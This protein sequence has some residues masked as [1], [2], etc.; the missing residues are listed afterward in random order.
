M[1]ASIPP[2]EWTLQAAAHLLNR[3]GFGGTPGEIQ[4]LHALGQSR[5]IDFL[6]GAD[7]ESDLFPAPDLELIA[8]KIRKIRS[9]YLELDKKEE[10]LA[11]ARREER[12]NGL[13]LR[14]WWLRRMR[15]TPNPARE[16]A[17][18]F[19]H[20][21]WA[22]SI[23]KVKNPLFMYRQNETLR[24]YAFGRF[25]PLAKE[26][27]RDPAMIRYLDLDSSSAKKPNENF[28]RE[29][30]E[31]FTLGEGNYSETDISE[32]ARA[33]AGYR[34]NKETGAFRFEPRQADCGTK[35]V[36]GTLGMHNGDE[37]IDIIVAKP[38]CAE[39]LATKIWS[40]YAETTPSKAFQKALGEEYVRTG[41][42]AGKFLRVLFLSREFYAPNVVRHQIKSPVQWL[43]QMCKILEIPLPPDNVT[44]PIMMNLGQNL[45]DP[46]NV[47][48]WNGA[49]A[50]INS[51]TL[52]L[53]YN[54]AGK[55]IRGGGGTLPDIDKIIPS[56]LSPEQSAEALA[57]RLFQSPMSDQLHEQTCN[58]IAANGTSA[59]ARRDLLHLLMATPEFQ[60]I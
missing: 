3:A 39:F 20:G 33:F 21:H 56:G 15:E 51:S 4:N 12:N 22:T 19:W 16:K 53:R 60:L 17:A 43:V 38:Q 25:A 41:M 23:R 5:A 28:A 50:W 26:I 58:F 35:T 10:L 34:I 24:A 13:A 29:V 14:Y 9:S 8:P 46:P 49:R 42:E 7:E 2:S 6:L 40:F 11:T 36:L 59:A 31:L 1:F 48:G 57:W 30:L 54:T 37:V 45:F 44:L 18:L 55:L 27:T 32:A 52:L 47:K